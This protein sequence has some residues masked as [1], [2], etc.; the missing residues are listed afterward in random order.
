MREIKF[1][2]FDNGNTTDNGIAVMTKPFTLVEL[3]ATNYLEYSDGTHAYLSDFD[4]ENDLTFMQYTGLKDKNGVEIYEGDILHHWK[5]GNRFVEFGS[6]LTNYAGYML[7][8]SQVMRGTL[9]D[10]DKLYEVIGNVYESPELLE[11][12]DATKKM[13]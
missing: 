1:R 10:T 9:Q 6:T 4:W 8:N 7:V 3:L 5:Q 13:G 11:N 2:A 12:K